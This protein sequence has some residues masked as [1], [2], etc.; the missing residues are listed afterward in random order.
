VGEDLLDDRPPEDGRD[1]LDLAAASV[2]VVLH[3]EIEL[4]LEQPCLANAVL[5]GLGDRRLHV[6]CASP[7]DSFRAM[8]SGQRMSLEGRN[9]SS[10]SGSLRASNLQ[11]RLSDDESEGAAVAT[12]PIPAGGDF[13]A[14]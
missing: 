9:D 5:P 4:S 13:L 11:R 7:T 14:R 8:R 1:D 2:R 6:I 10:A 3:V 12:R